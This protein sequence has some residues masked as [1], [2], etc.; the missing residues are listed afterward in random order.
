MWY[1]VQLEIVFCVHMVFLWMIMH[2]SKCKICVMIKLFPNLSV[3][4]EQIC[5]FKY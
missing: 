5:I 4:L 3:A 1:V 2:I